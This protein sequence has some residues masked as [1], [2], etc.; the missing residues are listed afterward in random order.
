MFFGC[1]FNVKGV[2]QMSLKS[3]RQYN[4]WDCWR[5]NISKSMTK[6]WEKRKK[7]ATQDNP[8]AYI[9]FFSIGFGM[10]VGGQLI[11]GFGLPLSYTH[12]F[13]GYLGIMI[14]VLGIINYFYTNHKEVLLKW[15]NGNQKMEKN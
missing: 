12:F 3:K 13:I 14:I 4:D 11:I 5:K 8:P 2:G 10:L 9:L 6:S 15:L 1:W 7:E